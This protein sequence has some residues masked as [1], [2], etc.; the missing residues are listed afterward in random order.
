MKKSLV[1]VVII[2]LAALIIGTTLAAG[3]GLIRL[4]P[5]GS[6]YPEPV[7]LESPATFTVWV[8]SGPEAIDPHIF[9]VMTDSCYQGL[10]SVTVDWPG[11]SDPDLTVTSWTK[12]TTQ[13]VPPGCHSGVDYTAASLKDHL[14]T[15]EDV[16]YAFEPF[17]A[18]PIT[19]TPQPFTVTLESTDPRMMVYALGKAPGETLFT[20]RVPP[21]QPGFVVPEVATILLAAASFSA[22]AVY[23]LL[24]KRTPK[25]S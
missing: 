15:E 8:Q 7:M 1:S 13:K 22:F 11:G 25:T 24:R 5:H 19:E 3:Q 10:T 23:A 21:T 16:W 17:L 4:D 12:V 14:S 6:Y 9:L 2:S 20:N 18:G